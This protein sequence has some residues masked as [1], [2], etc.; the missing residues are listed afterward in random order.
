[1]RRKPSRRSSATSTP[2]PIRRP[3]GKAGYIV[4]GD[5]EDLANLRG[6]VEPESV[7]RIPVDPARLYQVRF[8]ARSVRKRK[9]ILRVSV[10]MYPF[11]AKH[12]LFEDLMRSTMLVRLNCNPP[13]HDSAAGPQWQ[14]MSVIFRL[15]AR[16]KFI[17]LG[18]GLPDRGEIDLADVHVREYA[19]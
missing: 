5:S 14:R 12:L 10:R 16:T 15:P 6:G 17:R 4:C 2:L 3:D 8:R 13:A 1:M 7:D 18:I 11:G 9:G 19:P